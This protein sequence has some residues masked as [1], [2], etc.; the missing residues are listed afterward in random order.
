[1]TAL[2]VEPFE[3]ICQLDPPGCRRTLTAVPPHDHAAESGAA[4]TPGAPS[5]PPRPLGVPGALDLAPVS[6]Y[7]IVTR[8][9]IEATQRDVAEIKGRINNLMVMVCGAVLVNIVLR[10]A[11]LG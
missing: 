5:E 3:P 11:G 2:H 8:Q 4:P 9:M 10:M 1:M 7:E 6:A